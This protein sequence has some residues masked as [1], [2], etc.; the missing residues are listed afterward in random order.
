MA[1][2]GNMSVVISPCHFFSPSTTFPRATF[3]IVVVTSLSSLRYTLCELCTCILRC[4]LVYYRITVFLYFS[5]TILTVRQLHVLS[6]MTFIVV[7][8]WVLI[9]PN[10][11][12][13]QRCFWQHTSFSHLIMNRL[14][15][16]VWTLCKSNRSYCTIICL[17]GAR[18]LAVT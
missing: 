7:Q 2:W 17:V 10:L 12:R 15:L 5:D 9:L 6:R 1:Q 4:L 13:T 8:F 16:A 14:I 18:L 3:G 11:G